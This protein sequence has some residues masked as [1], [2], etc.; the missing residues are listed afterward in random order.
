MIFERY[1]PIIEDWSAFSDACRQP[2][3]TCIWRHPLR[4]TA[5]RFTE[6]FACDRV[7]ISP[8][9]WHPGA[10]RL[11]PDFSA[12]RRMEYWA[13]L[14]HVQEEIA[15]LPALLLAPQP[16]ECVV[17]LCA[18]PGNKTAQIALLMQNTGSVVANEVNASRMQPL[19]Q[20]INRLGLTNVTTTVSNATTFPRQSRQFDR[21]LAD[22]VCSCEGTS[23]KNPKILDLQKNEYCFKITRAQTAILVKALQLCKPE[24]RIVYATCTYA[25]EEN[26]RVVQSALEAVAPRI[27]ARILSCQV[28]GLKWAP[29]LLMWQGETYRKDMA[30]A[31]RIYPHL[32]DTGGFFVALLEKTEDSRPERARLAFGTSSSNS[33]IKT[34]ESKPLL[35]LIENRFGIS[36]EYFERFSIFRKNSKVASL[37]TNEH[38]LVCHPRVETVGL[39]LIHINMKCPKLTTSAAQTFGHLATKHVLRLDRSQADAFLRGETFQAA[40]EQV[41]N[42][43]EDGYVLAQF[44]EMILGVGLFHMRGGVGEVR[45]Q[46][47]RA[48][49]MSSR[50]N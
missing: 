22:V 4:T 23:R 49:Q 19:R 8:V 39:P 12:G 31:L 13:G 17:D 3:P 21:V 25:P 33:T 29:G 48:W 28:V 7:P 30:N 44:E 36:R 38:D 5:T 9:A 18:A 37:V 15:L 14:Y 46:F 10:Y 26:E 42:F 34:V 47:P 32:N 6:R 20:V 2:L 27:Q 43:E 41:C 16:G 50:S 45:S 1:K 35:E 11:P 40:R 24:G